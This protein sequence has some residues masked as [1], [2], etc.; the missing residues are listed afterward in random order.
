MFAAVLK[1]LH[2]VDCVRANTSSRA[3]LNTSVNADVYNVKSSLMRLLANLVY[4]HTTNQHMVLK[5]T[6]LLTDSSCLCCCTLWFINLCKLLVKFFCCC[7]C[8]LPVSDA[9]QRCVFSMIRKH[10][11]FLV[12]FSAVI[13]FWLLDACEV[14]SGVCL[15]CFL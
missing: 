13:F 1:S 11:L 12:I 7:V 10:K 9:Y 8:V 5:R 6:S 3:A 2:S 14:I 4:Q 15:V